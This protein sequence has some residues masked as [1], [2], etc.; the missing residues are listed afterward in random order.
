MAFDVD[1]PWPSIE[2]RL[3]AG[4]RITK[5]E[6]AAALRSH[7]NPP[8]SVCEWI[9]D[10][11]DGKP[12]GKG[13][14]PLGQFESLRRHLSHPTKLAVRRYYKLRDDGES[15]S[16]AKAKVLEEFPKLKGD[17]NSSP[18][19]AAIEKGRKWAEDFPTNK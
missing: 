7:P 3:E 4:Q 10:R 6:V 11:L 2:K 12:I 19:D 5:A 1:N 13:A 9:A 17:S 14:P 15:K 18:L 16:K 8:L